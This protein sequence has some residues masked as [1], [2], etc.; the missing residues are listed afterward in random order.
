M[1]DYRVRRPK[2]RRFSLRR[3]S[4]KANSPN[5]LAPRGLKS[6][7]ALTSS[8]PSRPP[9]HRVSTALRGALTMLRSLLRP[10]RASAAAWFL[11]G[12]LWLGGGTAWTALDVWNEP[13]SALDIT[14][15]EKLT[16]V[17][18][19]AAAGLYPG[20]PVGGLDPLRMAERLLAL[21]RLAWVDVRRTFPG[22]VDI[23]VGERRPVAVALLGAGH[24]AVL[25][26]EG[27]VLQSGVLPEVPGPELP[28]LL[29]GGAEVR[30]GLRVGEGPLRRGLDFAA[31]LHLLP[32]LAGESITVDARDAFAIRVKLDGR[33][34]TLILPRHGAE[35][36]LQ[37][38]LEAEPAL[39]SAAPEFRT[40]DARALP[41]EGVAWIALSR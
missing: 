7:P 41:R 16:P 20:V 35:H 24:S 22:R 33:G 21:P 34:R 14:G 18:I 9:R 38:Y 23:R 3:K 13:L 2:P 1:Q 29:G 5:A 31:G 19:A 8:G 37:R 27:V 11:A 26:R 17:Q 28:R 40:A 15:Q 36:A 32:P 39:L 10:G 4:K 12:M 6:A 25:D 30:D